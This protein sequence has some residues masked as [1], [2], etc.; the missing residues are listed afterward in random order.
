MQDKKQQKSKKYKYN[1]EKVL[2]LLLF[3]HLDGA[4]RGEG[5]VRYSFSATRR[6]S[7]LPWM[8][9]ESCGSCGRT[10]SSDPRR[11]RSSCR[12]GMRC[13]RGYGACSGGA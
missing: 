3:L 5:E 6:K 1:K 13:S 4:Q 2:L 10:G 8:L 11:P 7:R 9:G 12:H